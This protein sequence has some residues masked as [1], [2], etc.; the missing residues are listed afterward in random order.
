MPDAQSD[1][2]LST[3]SAIASEASFAAEL[4]AAGAP[5]VLV[6]PDGVTVTMTPTYSGC[7]A[8]DAIAF[9][10]KMKLIANGIKI[11]RAH[12]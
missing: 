7:P 4:L 10:I 1:T 6:R 12:V 2:R 5:L 11:G 3:T 9:D 8:M